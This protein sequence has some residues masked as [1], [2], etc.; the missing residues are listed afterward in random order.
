MIHITAGLLKYDEK[1]LSQ[2]SEFVIAYYSKLVLEKIK[3]GDNIVE[4]NL[5]KNLVTKYANNLNKFNYKEGKVIECEFDYLIVKIFKDSLSTRVYSQ[6]VD[7][8]EGWHAL[9]EFSDKKSILSV[10][11]P[12]ISSDISIE[13]F[14]EDML[15]L[16]ASIRHELQHDR[17]FVT[18]KPVEGLPKKTKNKLNMSSL[19]DIEQVIL[20][21]SEF[22]PMLT[23]ATSLYSL[24][25]KQILSEYG[26]NFY[27][28]NKSWYINYFIGDNIFF[29][30]LKKY[31]FKKY[32]L[33]VK[34]F[35]QSVDKD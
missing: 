35:Y 27:M 30:T 20:D 23:D 34:H 1:M 21:D 5:L 11:L 15:R 9:Y 31:D 3:P 33:A 28:K 2:I 4:F 29:E 24:F 17:Q 25:K 18:Y 10:L 8:I 7:V 22:Y 14:K 16:V 19:D 6:E 32:K 12:A 26:L 13:Q